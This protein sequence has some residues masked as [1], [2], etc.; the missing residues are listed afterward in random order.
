MPKP[1]SVVR[2][3]LMSIALTIVILTGAC[4]RGEVSQ[5]AEGSSADERLAFYSP[6]AIKI[7]PF[8][9]PRS[10]DED[11]VP[12]GLGVSLRVLDSTDDPTKAIGTFT[13]ELY[14]YR[15]ASQSRRGALLQH[16]TQHVGPNHQAQFWERITGSYEFQL[17]WEGS[18]IPPQKKYILAATFQ[19]GPGTDRLFHEYEFEFRVSREEVFGAATRQDD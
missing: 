15:P 10:F 14:A 2:P 3:A 12:D 13:F 19:A 6:Q 5:I 18:P 1:I 16:W 7:L 17:S 8:T 4:Q 9:K 11:L